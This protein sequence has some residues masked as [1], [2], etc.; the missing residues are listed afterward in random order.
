MSCSGPAVVVAV[1]V[2]VVEVGVV[3]VD[4]V[5]LWLDVTVVEVVGEVVC[6]D[7]NEVEVV[8][9]V[10]GD[11]VNVVLVVGEEVGEVVSVVVVVGEVVSVV[12]VCDV[13]TE[14]VGVVTSQSVKPRGFVLN[15]ASMLL[16]CSA[17]TSHS[18]GS[19][20]KWN[21]SSHTRPSSCMAGPA[22]SLTALVNAVAVTSQVSPASTPSM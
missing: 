1:D 8:G 16:R 14:V 4:G 20:V 2:A 15:A 17:K 12:V 13:V 3:L 6:D 7:V 19:I 21:A 9:V 5:V 18:S 22:N 10:D 11:V